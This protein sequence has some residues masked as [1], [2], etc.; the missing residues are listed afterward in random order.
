MSPKP[1]GAGTVARQLIRELQSAKGVKIQC[2]CCS[3]SRPA[4]KYLM[5][6]AGDTPSEAKELLAQQEAALK[7]RTT[8]QQLRVEQLERAEEHAQRINFGNF[9]ERLIPATPAFPMNPADYRHLGSP[10]DY[11]AFHGISNSGI[12]DSIDFIDAKAGPAALKVNQKLIANAVARG[13]V[14]VR[15][16]GAKKSHAGG[17]TGTKQ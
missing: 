4:S 16:I 6:A 5:F 17:T 7:A 8:K 11:I 9:A 14:S 1:S 13:R 12:I 2:P 15:V 10:I 3:E